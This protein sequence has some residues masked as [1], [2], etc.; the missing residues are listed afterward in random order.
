MLLSAVA[1]KMK[2]ISKVEALLA[3]SA[4]QSKIIT[5]ISLLDSMHTRIIV[6]KWCVIKTTRQK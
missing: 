4:S 3:A 1:S 5:S 6:K 2:P